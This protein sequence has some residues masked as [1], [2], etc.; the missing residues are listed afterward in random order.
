MKNII[1][2]GLVVVALTFGLFQIS[3]HREE[4]KTNERK[5]QEYVNYTPKETELPKYLYEDKNGVYHT[6]LNCF[7]LNPQASDERY[8]IDRV[9]AKDNY[10]VKRYSFGGVLL[11]IDAREVDV[12]C[13]GC[14]S[15]EMYDALIKASN[16]AIGIKRIDL[17][18]EI[19]DYIP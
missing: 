7:H 15:D 3:K 1:Y 6:S 8:L 4:K 10:G 14:V 2:V 13:S 17:E 11:G 16:E 5:E 9:E 19:I 12:W 18:E